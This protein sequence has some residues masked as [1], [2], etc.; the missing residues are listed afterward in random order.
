MPLN[1]FYP[2]Y[3]I[4]RDFDKCINCRVCERQCSNNVHSFYAEKNIMEADSS[5]CVNCQRCVTLCPAAALKEVKSG[6]TFRENASWGFQDIS[7]IYRQA[8]TG[9]VLLASMGVPKQYRYIGIK[10]SLTRRRLQTL[11]LTPLENL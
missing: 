6:N 5:K 11:L 7:D 3:E 9:G 10:C 2:E 4:I 1:Y 8:E